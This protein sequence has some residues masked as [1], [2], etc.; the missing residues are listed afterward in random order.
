M[1]GR[2]VERAVNEE[3]AFPLVCVSEEG[4]GGCCTQEQ[5]QLTSEGKFGLCVLELQ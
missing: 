2:S 1:L 4:R 5:L 3:N